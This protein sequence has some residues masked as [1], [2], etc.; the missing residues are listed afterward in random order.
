MAKRKE[1]TVYRYTGHCPECGAEQEGR[2]ESKA[3]RVCDKCRKKHAAERFE[4][5]IGFLKGAKIT[6]F[7]G[8][9]MVGYDGNLGACVIS[10]LTVLTEDGR[11]IN[12]TTSRGLW[13][14]EEVDPDA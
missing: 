2:S 14:E 13:R 6:D 3:D 8:D 1:T 11:T 4:E 12:I 5:K 10:E 7:K 9:C